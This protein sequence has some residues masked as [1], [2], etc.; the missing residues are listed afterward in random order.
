MPSSS[1]H[2]RRDTDR[3]ISGG[4]FLDWF[5]VP[6]KAPAGAAAAP[7]AVRGPTQQPPATT[8]TIDPMLPAFYSPP[9]LQTVPFAQQQQQAPTV[10]PGSQTG[11]RT[12]ARQAAPAPQAPQA[13]TIIAPLPLNPSMPVATLST[14]VPVMI[15]AP[16]I[17]ASRSTPVSALSKLAA[18]VNA[19]STPTSRYTTA[20]T[21]STGDRDY[22]EEQAQQEFL[23][24][25]SVKQA[26]RTRAQQQIQ[27]AQRELEET[28]RE[29][30]MLA[31]QYQQ[32]MEQLREQRRLREIGEQKQWFAATG[33]SNREDSAACLL[34]IVSQHP[35]LVLCSALG[36]NDPNLP[37]LCAGTNDD[38]KAYILDRHQKRI[39]ASMDS[40]GHMKRYKQPID[41]PQVLRR[42]ILR[43]VTDDD[44]VQ[45]QRQ[46]SMAPLMSL[47]DQQRDESRLFEEPSS[48]MRTPRRST[49]N[50]LYHQGQTYGLQQPPSANDSATT[51][52]EQ[53]VEEVRERQTPS[54]TLD[55]EESA[56]FTLPSPPARPPSVV[57]SVTRATTL[58]TNAGT[59][60]PTAAPGATAAST[61]TTPATPVTPATPSTGTART[62]PVITGGSEADRWYRPSRRRPRAY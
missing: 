25:Q 18:A 62:P 19:T 26:Q 46:V 2:R 30:E 38:F 34:E 20:T 61:L 52:V 16:A 60:T 3:L 39:V 56:D 57:T 35:D 6:R 54:S 48:S 7:A 36:N 9:P 45:L 4:G 47:R 22:S 14:N 13:P 33:C 11:R 27:E 31:Q 21:T 5:K 42:P 59:R 49:P 44:R 50:L 15:G 41:I 1:S 12:A 32:R 24:E 17:I 53:V 40:T 51:S 10:L 43:P 55:A 28:Q 58:T 29:E 37:S 23:Q 8:F